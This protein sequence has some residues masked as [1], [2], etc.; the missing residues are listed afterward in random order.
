MEFYW[1]LVFNYLL[2]C[3]LIHT[4]CTRSMILVVRSVLRSAT[5]SCS[6]KQNKLCLNTEFSSAITSIS[7]IVSGL[8][9]SPSPPPAPPSSESISSPLSDVCPHLEGLCEISFAPISFSGVPWKISVRERTDERRSTPVVSMSHV[10][11]MNES[12]RA[13]QWVMSRMSISHVTC[14]EATQHFRARTYGWVPLSACYV[15]MPCHAY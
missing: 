6:P 8:S 14:A 11:H 7:S 4:C 13:F 2:A 3:S 5:S 12:C 9:T 1:L 10:T 15:N